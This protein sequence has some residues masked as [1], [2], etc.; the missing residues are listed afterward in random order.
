MSF[1]HTD[2]IRKHLEAFVLLILVSIKKIIIT[3]QFL[4]NNINFRRYLG[5]SSL[6]S[7]AES[8]ETGNRTAM[9]GA[10]R[11]SIYCEMRQEAHRQIEKLESELSDK[12][13]AADLK[14]RALERARRLKEAHRA[15]LQDQMEKIQVSF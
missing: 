4:F 9:T 5:D 1:Q 12:L 14:F 11:A 15:R 13:K 10:N 8:Q 2:T 3:E 7:L 6:S